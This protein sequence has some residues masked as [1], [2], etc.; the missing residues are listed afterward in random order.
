MEKYE[1]VI[2]L[3]ANIHHIFCFSFAFI[4]VFLMCDSPWDFFT[5]DEKCFMTYKP[6]YSHSGMWSMGYLTFDLML[7]L[8][9]THDYKSDLGK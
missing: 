3:N 1:L 7:I 5:A 2:L 4:N 6:F 8:F 9:L